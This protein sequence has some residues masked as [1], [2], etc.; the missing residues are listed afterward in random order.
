MSLDRFMELSGFSPATCW[1][2]RRRGWLRT[3][4]IAGRHYVPRKEIAE[5]N[6]RAAD[7]EFAG[8]VANPSKYRKQTDDGD[9]ALAA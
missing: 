1:R 8:K 2:Y 7:G 6:R 5:F 3:V 9:L 4:T